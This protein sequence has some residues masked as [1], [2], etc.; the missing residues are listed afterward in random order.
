MAKTNKD[1]KQIISQLESLKAHTMDMERGGDEIWGIDTAALTEAMDIINDYGIM[2]EQYRELLQKY[3]RP[4]MARKCSAGVY[5]CP[6]CGKRTQVGHSHCHWC[7]KK[8]SWSRESYAARDYP[9]LK[10]GGKR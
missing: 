1:Y 10:R 8:L 3:E 9:H 6:L 2:A 7:G 4:E 5:V